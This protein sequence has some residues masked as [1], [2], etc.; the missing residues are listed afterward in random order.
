MFFETGA[1]NGSI[2]CS[3]DERRICIIGRTKIDKDKSIFGVNTVTVPLFP[4]QIPWAALGSHPNLGGEK[5]L[6][7]YLRC[8]TFQTISNTQMNVNTQTHSLY[9]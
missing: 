9:K 7:Y 2:V 6:T 3:P 5:M 1:F 8:S 4:L